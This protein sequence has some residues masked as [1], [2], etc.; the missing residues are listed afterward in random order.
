MEELNNDINN[1]DNDNNV[2]N[3]I[4]TKKSL[5]LIRSFYKDLL[6]I[7][8]DFTKNLSLAKVNY[9]KHEFNLLKFSNKNLLDQLQLQQDKFFENFNSFNEFIH[10]LSGIKISVD[11]DDNDKLINYLNLEEFEK[12]ILKN[13]KINFNHLQ[14]LIIISNNLISLLSRYLNDKTKLRNFDINFKIIKWL[15]EFNKVYEPLLNEDL[16]S[17]ELHL[18]NLI[19]STLNDINNDDKLLLNDDNKQLSFIV[20][21]LENYF[22]ESKSLFEDFSERT[23]DNFILED[24]INLKIF[25]SLQIQLQIEG[26][27]DENMNEILDNL[28]LFDQ[29]LLNLQSYLP[30]KEVFENELSRKLNFNKLINSIKYN[31]DQK[32]NHLLEIENFNNQTFLNNLLQ[33]FDNL[34]DEFIDKFKNFDI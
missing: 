3:I 13:L 2:N 28:K 14:N 8:S 24:E 34:P 5:N 10:D 27:F 23:H 17:I 19:D 15:N 16:N 29:F 22:N 18:N 11:N 31:N 4:F 12:N 25:N 30:L 21:E 26:S 7:K 1:N 20:I 32:I 9:N 33:N 6:S